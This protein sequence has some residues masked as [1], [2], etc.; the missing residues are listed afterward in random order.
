MRNLK[1]LSV[2]LIAA[3]LCACTK[4][5]DT[6][7]VGVVAELTG[8]IP[9]VGN[10]CKNGAQLA[11]KEINAAGGVDVGG[12]KYKI[13]LFIEDSASKPE[14]AAAVAQKLITKNRVLAIVGPNSSANA[15][16]VSEIAENSKVLFITPWSTNP[17]TT[18]DAKTGQP[19]QYAF[20]ACFT[21]TFEGGV[22]GKFASETL[23]AKKAAVLF[24]VA[25][26]VLK[27]QSE[28]FK[29][30]FEKAGGKVVA[31]ETYTGGDKDFSAQFT[32]IKQANPDIIFLPS[33]YTDVPLQVSQAHRLGIKA[34]FLGSDA[35][36]TEELV[37]MCGKECDGFYFFNHYSPETT[38]PDTVKFISTY[39]TEYSVV[40]DDVAA[41]SYDAVGVLSRAFAAAGKLDR[42]AVRDAMG[43]LEVY[44]GVTG[45]IKYT[46][47]S[48]DPIKGGVILQI[49][50]G[51]FKWYS[52]AKP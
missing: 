49:K 26:D 15:L 46:P 8:A 43:G 47:G 36:S 33:Y 38:N 16:P 2:L 20:R 45:S 13:E 14:Q 12:K 39:K 29:E 34:P 27:V 10:S 37:T 44:N 35:W 40:P 18:L 3:M 51:K 4:K 9:A 30:S 6:I 21:D 28:L 48:G 50:D 5:E 17:K 52:D 11:V 7:R 22:L 25:A 41:L 23:K 1:I 42:Q 31:F 24:D 19:K 32:K